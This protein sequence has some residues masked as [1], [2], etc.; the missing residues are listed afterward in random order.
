MMP[1]VT[2]ELFFL[3]SLKWFSLLQLMVISEPK[4]LKPPENPT[5]QPPNHEP[6]TSNTNP[7]LTTPKEAAEITG[8]TFRFLLNKTPESLK[9]RYWGSK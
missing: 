6:E 1:K 9:V 8:L 4:G 5:L 3:Q 2:T 7:K